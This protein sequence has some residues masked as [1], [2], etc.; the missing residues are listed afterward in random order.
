MKQKLFYLGILSIVFIASGCVVRT[1]KIVK[2]RVDQ[3]LEAGNQ[4]Y[5]SGNAP[6][7]LSAKERKVTRTSRVIEVEFH[8]PLKFEK[9]PKNKPASVSSSVLEDTSRESPLPEV[10]E[11]PYEEPAQEVVMQQYQV[12]KKDTLQSISQKFYGT[13]KKWMKIYQANKDTL[14]A[15]D[16]IYPGQTINI[17]LD[18]AK[19]SRQESGDTLPKNAK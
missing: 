11:S 7:D 2:D 6:A 9:K 3:D 13:T 12:Q 17:P 15:P 16:K 5:L 14:K 1:Y 8:S 4:G 18:S 19:S 10:S